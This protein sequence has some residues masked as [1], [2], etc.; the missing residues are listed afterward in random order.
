MPIFT[1]VKKKGFKILNPKF[2]M[3]LYKRKYWKYLLQVGALSNQSLIKEIPLLYQ[4]RRAPSVW[5][6]GSH[7]KTSLSIIGKIPHTSNAM[8]IRGIPI[9]SS[10]VHIFSGWWKKFLPI[11]RPIPYRI[12]I[13]SA[14]AST[15]VVT[16]CGTFRI[17]LLRIC[18]PH[19]L[20]QENKCHKQD[21]PGAAPHC[22]KKGTAKTHT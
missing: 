2:I 17:T 7:F 18:K 22:H 4:I 9:Y 1:G 20:W 13:N 15:I 3:C 6:H 19:S 8:P 10:Q 5:W 14:H 16:M 21:A 11:K 12:I